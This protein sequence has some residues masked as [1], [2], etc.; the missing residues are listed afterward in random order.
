[1]EGE[2]FSHRGMSIEGGHAMLLVGYNDAFLTRDGFTGGLI[3]KNSWA[4]GPRQG[5]HTLKYW[6]QEVSDWEERV[7]CPNSYNPHNWYQCGNEGI[8]ASNGFNRSNAFNEGIQACLSEEAKIYAKVNVQ[9]I[10]LKCKDPKQCHIEED[11]TYFVRNTTDWGDRMTV[12]CLWEYSEKQHISREICLKPMLEIDIAKTLQPV[13]EEVQEND[14]DRCGFYF[15][16]YEALRHWISQFQ[17]FF[18]NNFEIE[19]DPQSYAANKEEYPELDY[20]LLEK[21]T[22][23]QH[24]D[25]FIGPFPNAKVIKKFPQQK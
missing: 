22:K 24:Q 11:F 18:V 7:V 10:H 13:A 14:T 23:K 19:W 20:T 5:S 4:D 15:I 6:L 25:D 1:M 2:F 3:V 21:S 9:P 17:G 8:S 12:M 16:P